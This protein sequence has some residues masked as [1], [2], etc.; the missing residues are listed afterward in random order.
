MKNLNHIVVFH[1]AA[2]GDAM[3]ATPVAAILKRNFPDA[4]ISYW[5]H[6]S[7][8]IIIND[9]C[10]SVDDFVDYK[11]GQNIFSLS[12]QLK[13]LKA[14]LFID[15]SNSTKGKLIPFF[16]G[17]RALHYKKRA[18]GVK[19]VRHAADNFVDTIRS[20]VT[21]IPEQLFPTVFPQTDLLE[22]SK[23]QFFQGL[24]ESRTIVGIVPGVGK[25]RP[26]RAWTVDGVVEL[27][28][29]L[30]SND[31]N[32]PVLLGG[33]DERDLGAEIEKRTQGKVVNLC[34]KLD[35][36]QTAAVLKQCR[37]V[38]SGDTGPAHI[39]VAVGTPVIGLYGPTAV[40]RSGP[41]GN[42]DLAIDRQSN[43]RCQ[44]EKQCRF[45]PEGTAGDCM[46]QITTGDVMDK[47]EL[48]MNR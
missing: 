1:P 35:L 23:Q 38:I 6:G 36:A 41:Y 37:L 30:N 26:N 4:H 8:K 39:A 42:L 2:I 25:I 16:C 7:L 21:D 32:F 27:I 17:T 24:N 28:E 14:D 12:S 15:L 20:L 9:M 22:V 18:D 40:E 10:P 46:R 31:S 11:R 45:S 48:V 44:Y 34:G 29:R 5:T 43:C 33:S 13:A 19:P 47:I 3:L